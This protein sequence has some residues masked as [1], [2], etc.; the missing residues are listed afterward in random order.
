MIS[1]KSGIT[2]RM[3]VNQISEQGRATQGVK[4]IRVDDGDEIAAI[5]RLDEE[6]VVEIIDA[7]D[8]TAEASDST[9]TTDNNIAPTDEAPE[10]TDNQ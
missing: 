9:D 6:E 1:C 7:T 5:T 8:V 4:L 3:K 10:S 2:I